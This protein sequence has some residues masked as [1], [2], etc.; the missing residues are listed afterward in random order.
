MNSMNNSVRLIGYIGADP[1]VKT[2]DKGVN[3]ARMRLATN[4]RYKLKNGEW[5]NETTWHQVVLWDKLA[6]R[7]GQQLFKGSMVLIEGK[8]TSR[9]Y[10]NT[11]GQAQYITEIR[12]SG[13]MLLEKKANQQWAETPQSD[14]MEESLP[15]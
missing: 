13:F 8:L 4:D 1:E 10:V 15:F 12:A 6:D 11:A 3:V 9:S 7:A 5:Q 14:A 2:L